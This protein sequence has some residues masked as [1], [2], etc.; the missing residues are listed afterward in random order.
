MLPNEKSP[1]PCLERAERALEKAQS[2]GG[3][4]AQMILSTKT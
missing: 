3:N 4:Q 1:L 2:Y